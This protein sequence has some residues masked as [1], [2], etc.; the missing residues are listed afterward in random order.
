M[1]KAIKMNSH[2]IFVYPDMDE[3][4]NFLPAEI[5]DLGNGPNKSS[6]IC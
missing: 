4:G 6:I 2:Y 5:L 1:R 3:Q